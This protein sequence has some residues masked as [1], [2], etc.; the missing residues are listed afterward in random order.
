MVLDLFVKFEQKREKRER[1][2]VLRRDRGSP[3]CFISK[4]DV[5]GKKPDVNFSSRGL[6]VTS[7]EFVRGKKKGKEQEKKRLQTPLAI[8]GPK[9]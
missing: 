3:V 2:T 8:W 7:V 4:L 9:N 1:K 5:D 6:L